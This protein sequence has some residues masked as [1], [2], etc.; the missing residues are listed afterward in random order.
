LRSQLASLILVLSGLLP[1]T[2]HAAWPLD[3]APLCT[4]TAGQHLPAIVSDGAGGTIVTWYDHRNGS[5]D[6]YAQ[7]LDAFGNPLWAA[8]GVALCGAAND[9]IDPKIVSDSAGGAIVTWQDNR[10]GGPPDRYDIYAQR[11]NASGVSQWPANGV[12]LCIN[13]SYQYYPAIVS[14]GAGGAIVMWDDYRGGNPIIH[15]QRVNTSGAPQWTVDGVALAAAS[16]YQVLAGTI[17]DGAGGAIATWRD[18]RMGSGNT[19]VYARRVNAS[20]VP[21]WTADGTAVCTF[22]NHQVQVAIASDGAGGAI[23]TWTDFRNAGIPDIYAQR[24]SAAGAALWAVDGVALCTA[25]ADQV[26]PAIVSDGAGGAIVAW[27]DYRNG[28]PDIYAQRVDAAGGAQWLVGGVALCVAPDFQQRQTLVSEGAGGA[29][30]T[31]DDFR[32][33]A[34]YDA[35]VQHVSASGNPSWT[36]DGI[37]VST[38]A[39]NQQSPAIVANG[40]GGAIIAWNDS[41]KGD[42]DI[43]AQRIEGRYGEYGLPEPTIASASDNPSDQGGRIILRWNG[44]GRD[45]FNDPLIAQYSVW[46]ATD[47][48][49]ASAASSAG[50]EAR[51]ASDPR[52]IESDFA[53]TAIWKKMTPSGPEY[54][55][56]IANQSATYQSTYS[57]TAATRHDSVAT[58]PA[59]HYFKVISHE[60]TSP[61]T[62]MWESASVGAY[63]VDNLAP[64]APLLLIAQRVGSDVQLKWNRAVAPDLRDYSV[65]RATSTGVTPVPINFL[66]SSEDTIAVDAGAPATT[67]YYIVTAHDVHANQSAP[68]NEASVG[69]TTGV[70]NTPPITAFT[71]LDNMPNPFTSTTTL[72]VGLTE[73]SEVEIDV[74]DVAGRRVRSERTSTLAAGWREISFDARNSGGKSLASGVYFYRVKAAGETITRKMVIA[75]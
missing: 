31:W 56:W 25:A 17:P 36:A 24:M 50:S 51:V 48:V 65:Y 18:Y 71:V 60:S 34:T 9:Q 61:Q 28:D 13:A 7:R 5:A 47:F 54:W 12:A 39:G 4:A 11:V 22:T 19:D 40:T 73:A 69:A 26:L 37:A 44:S 1:A 10:G 52:E 70:G 64:A 59:I 67:L 43:Y 75:R 6:I 35:Y 68:S 27:Q 46:R 3:G 74:F 53:G 16:N 42:Y 41:R 45:P 29:I 33:G 55:E 62:R 32:S 20:G 57:F 15:A 38:A 72:R 8:N 49:A 63:S 21:Q 58:N 66:E 30:V 23:I 2:A 14:D